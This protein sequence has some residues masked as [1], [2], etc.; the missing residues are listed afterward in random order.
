MAFVQ[1]NPCLLCKESAWPGQA[2]PARLV[3]E[4]LH[5]KPVAVRCLIAA[6]PAA[7]V[8]AAAV[9]AVRPTG[10]DCAPQIKADVRSLVCVL[11]QC[12]THAFLCNFCGG[13]SG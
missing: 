9:A 6:D 3:P 13:L 1:A 8:A 10:P 7:A 4:A 5:I 2:T 11:H 12:N